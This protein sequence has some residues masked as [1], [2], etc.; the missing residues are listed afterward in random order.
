MKRTSCGHLAHLTCVVHCRELMLGS[1][2]RADL[3]ELDPDR[4]E[5]Y[6]RICAEPGG[7]NIQCAFSRCLVSFHPYCAYS[8]GLLMVLRVKEGAVGQRR[9][10][11]ETYCP[12]HAIMCRREGL[13]GSINDTPDQGNALFA[14]RQDGARVGGSS[15]KGSGNSRFEG[16]GVAGYSQ[17]SPTGLFN[18]QVHPRRSSRHKRMKR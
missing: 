8:K 16:S 4:E 17:E 12:G 14:T 15:G 10:V 3:S 2:M 18:T 11:Y 6:C 7:G 5:L 1:D 9:G 13:L